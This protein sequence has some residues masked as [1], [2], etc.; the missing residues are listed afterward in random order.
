MTLDEVK[1]EFGKSK[2]HEGLEVL[3]M[4]GPNVR[5]KCSKCGNEFTR[6]PYYLITRGR[7]CPI[8]NR[9]FVSTTEAFKQKVHDL[10]GDEYEVLGEYVNNKTKILMKHMACGTEYMVQPNK[11]L[12]GRRCPKCQHPSRKKTDEEFRKEIHDLVGDEY[13]VLDPYKGTDKKIRFKHTLCGNVY[14]T[15]PLVFISG[16]RCPKCQHPSTKKDIESVKKEIREIDKDYILISD[17]VNNRTPIKLRHKCGCEF[18]TYL[19]NFTKSKVRC[20]QCKDRQRSIL[21]DEV[22]DYIASIYTGEIKQNYKLKRARGEPELD[23]YIPEFRIGIEVDGLYWHSLKKK[24][25][26][27]LLDKTKYFS[28]NDIRVIHI[29]EDEWEEHPDIVKNKLS[30]IL[31]RDASPKIYARKCIAKEIGKD[32]AN[33]FLNAYHIQG[34][35]SAKYKIGLYHKDELVAVMTFTPS[36][37]VTGHS[38]DAAEL[39]RYATKCSVIGGFSKL[40][41]FAI[42][43]YGFKKVVTFADLRWSSPTDNV[44]IKNG[45]K[46]EH[47]SEPSY[48]YFKNC[49]RYHRSAFMKYKLKTKLPKYYSDDLTE[50]EIMHKAGYKEIYD[51]GAAV[52]SWEA[53][54]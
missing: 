51:C 38:E 18:E 4:D 39:F 49:K 24:S 26:Y 31:K 6:E 21:E 32:E 36:R 3:G 7:G 14:S 27:N 44:Y 52:F 28:K 5:V 13:E 11:F 12:I 8:C 25:K 22:Y 30:H 29:L 42:K 40:F 53:A 50:K 34:C 20:P 17:Y 10:V 16:A 1:R 54:V 46:L 47:L 43:T 35:G 2:L 9:A 41:K 33:P 19:H 48:W 15:T 45:F 37:F 23:I